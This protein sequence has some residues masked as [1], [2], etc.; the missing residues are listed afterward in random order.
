LFN[1]LSVL[2]RVL[3]KLANV[4]AKLIWSGLLF[5]AITSDGIKQTLAV[6]VRPILEGFF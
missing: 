3:G 1:R 4:S 2:F 5:G 6:A